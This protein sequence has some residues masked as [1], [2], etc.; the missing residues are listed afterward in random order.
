MITITN[1]YHNPFLK[2]KSQENNVYTYSTMTGDEVITKEEVDR[3]MKAGGTWELTTNG[4]NVIHY[5]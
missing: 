2:G 3:I 5:K 4:Y 1:R